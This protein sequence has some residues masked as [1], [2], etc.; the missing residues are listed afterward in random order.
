VDDHL[1]YASLP[2]ADQ[3]RIFLDIVSAD[4]VV[5]AALV[6][7][8][9]TALPDWLIVSGVLYNS[10]WNALT[11]RP[12]G[13][14]TKDIDLF[15][16]DSTDLSYDAEDVVISRSAPRF[17]GLPLPV[18]IRN[19]ARVHLWYPQKYGSPCPQYSNAAHSVA[20]FASKTHAVGVRLSADA[21]LELVAPFGVADIFAFRITPNHALDNRV[22]HERKGARAK[23]MWPQIIVEAW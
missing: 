13:Y 15:Y 6:A 11:G 9:D 14:G 2:D 20:Y 21:S 5:R 22:T 10:V 17:A 12:P 16:F 4:P 8:H 7:A 18:E 23:A 3:R 19:Q 1:R